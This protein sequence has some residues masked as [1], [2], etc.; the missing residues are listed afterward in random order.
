MPSS[1]F[2]AAAANS[3]RSSSIEAR[4]RVFIIST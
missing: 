1:I 3:S 4:A 2:R